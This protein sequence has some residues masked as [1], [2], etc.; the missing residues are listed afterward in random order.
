MK[1][2]T[3]KIEQLIKEKSF[4]LAHNSTG[5]SGDSLIIDDD[6]RAWAIEQ[7]KE[8]SKVKAETVHEANSYLMKNGLKYFPKST[9]RKVSEFLADF[10]DQ[11]EA[12]KQPEG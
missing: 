8:L 3:E 11:L 6:L 1:P 2:I 10:L 4:Y 9:I 7:D 12:D 5:E